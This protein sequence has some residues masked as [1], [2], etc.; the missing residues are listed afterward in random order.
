MKYIYRGLTVLFKYDRD[1]SKRYSIGKT[2]EKAG[3]FM[4]IFR[5]NGTH[6]VPALRKMFFNCMH[7]ITEGGL[8]YEIQGTHGN[9]LTH[10]NFLKLFKISTEKPE[11]FEKM[12]DRYRGNNETLIRWVENKEA[13]CY[14]T[15]EITQMYRKGGNNTFYQRG[16]NVLSAENLI[17]SNEITRNMVRCNGCQRYVIQYFEQMLDSIYCHDC[18]YELTECEGC[19]RLTFR[20][21]CDNCADFYSQINEYGSKPEKWWFFDNVKGFVSKKPSEMTGHNKRVKALYI[22][23][24][25]E[26]EISDRD[27]LHY[28]A[29]DITSA[30]SNELFY[31]TSDS[32]LECGFEMHTHPA[33]HKVHSA[34][35]WDAI[36]NL[37]AS[38]GRSYD[39]D[40]AGLHFHLNRSAFSNWH[41]LKFIKFLMDNI[42]VT[43]AVARR[44]NIS[45]L[46]SYAQ[47]E[48]NFFH[49]LKRNIADGVKRHKRDGIKY[50]SNPVTRNSS[51]GAIN[52]NNPKTIELRFCGGALDEIKYKCK[53]D[54]IQAVYEY[55]NN[56]GMKSQN[57]HSFV[58]YVKKNKN[59]F[60]NLFSE[61][62]GKEFKRA[63]QFP[64]E[65]PSKLHY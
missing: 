36:K 59:R 4:R 7:F 49:R 5:E 17:I 52:L 38:G 57:I 45:N 40:T 3:A 1:Y 56:A 21:K 63:V 47:F 9:G 31:T 27:D 12:L 42:S 48:F 18:A 25:H 60:R 2:L 29:E 16:G 61:M 8:V 35:K 6:Y 26:V 50:P 32:S 43:L 37:R 65:I 55:T 10:W 34:R 20:P 46:N 14:F 53:V 28:Y 15:G 19:D 64:A 23:D 41:F 51:R 62:T 39:T 54:F 22:G 33:T 24:E 13:L 11:I 58:D 44:K 30:Y